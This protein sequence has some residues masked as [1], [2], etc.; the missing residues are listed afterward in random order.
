MSHHRSPTELSLRLVTEASVPAPA[1]APRQTLVHALGGPGDVARA[2]SV[3]DALDGDGH[4]LQV[5]VHAGAPRAGTRRDGRDPLLGDRV[6]DY[7]LRVPD[8]T[9]GARMTE[10][11]T[12]HER[13]LS[14][15][16]PDAVVVYGAGNAALACALAA[17]KLGIAIAHVESGLRSADA[18]HTR[19]ANRILV[20]RLAD[21][22]LAPDDQAARNLVAEGIPDTRVHVVGLTHLDL[23]HRV[24]AEAILR[25][26]CARHALEDRGYVV[27]LLRD[28][29]NTTGPRGAAVRAAIARLA[30]A[31]PVV[32]CPPAG[33]LRTIDGT[34]TVRSPEHLDHLSLLVDAGAVITDS[35]AVRA[36]ARELGVA[37]HGLGAADEPRK[38]ERVRPSAPD[39]LGCPSARAE[40]AAG[41]R[42]AAVLLAHYALRLA[43]TQA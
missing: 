17:A 38:I 25:Q 12:H 34:I 18:G 28:R 40:G 21:T 19:N 10:L 7:W 1:P 32:A 5:L 42:V 6:P 3:I 26:A 15:E 37:C 43:G 14:S 9:Y 8:G 29:H 2:A 4:F 27:T 33:D 23:L 35:P 41:A 39:R 31:V 13:M 24:R 36:E 11:L 30:E 20:D 22:L 16:R